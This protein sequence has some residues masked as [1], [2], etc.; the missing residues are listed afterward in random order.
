MI[1]GDYGDY[2]DVTVCPLL[3]QYSSLLGDV[4]ISCYVMKGTVVERS[5]IYECNCRILNQIFLNW[6]NIPQS[7]STHLGLKIF[8]CILKP[9]PV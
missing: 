2:K 6:F 9:K 3:R 5:F 7:F 1:A 8:P 4:L